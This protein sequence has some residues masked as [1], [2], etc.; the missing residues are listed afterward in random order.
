MYNGLGRNLQFLPYLVSSASSILAGAGQA[1]I[2]SPARIR[3]LM[4]R[5]VQ[6]DGMRSIRNFH[7]GSRVM[8]F[9]PVDQCFKAAVVGVFLACAFTARAQAPAAANAPQAAPAT[10][11]QAAPAAVP[12]ASEAQK[13]M[14]RRVARRAARPSCEAVNDPWGDLCTIRK[15]AEVA[16]S[17]LSAPKARAK[18]QRSARKGAAASPPGNPRQECFDAYMRNV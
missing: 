2:E 1:C 8:N 14:K 5:E 18:A 13:P 11:P 10:A 12:M 15:H 7:R 17:D 3:D 4:L 16:C 6:P 9:K